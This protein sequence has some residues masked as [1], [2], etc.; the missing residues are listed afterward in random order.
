MAQ[1]QRMAF[2]SASVGEGFCAYIYHVSLDA[3][4][5]ISN[6]HLVSVECNPA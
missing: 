5:E 4:H 6:W 3:V 1:D 2:R